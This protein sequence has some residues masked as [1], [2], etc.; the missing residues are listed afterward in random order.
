M[1]VS[2]NH[3]GQNKHSYRKLNHSEVKPRFG[4]NGLALLGLRDIRNA[5][6]RQNN[7]DKAMAVDTETLEHLLETVRRFVEKRLIP[8]ESQVAEDDH[9]PD[10]VIDEMRELGL[11]GLTIPEA[12]GGLGLN[13][14][15][16]C[17]VV[18]ELGLTSPAFR[19]IIGTNNGI[20]SQGLVMD[21]T[22]EQKRHYLPR[23]ATGEIIGSFA[24]TE[25][26][27]GSDSGAVQTKA[28]KQGDDY[29]LSGTKRYI[30]NAGSAQLF[31]VFARTD[32][33]EVG[34]KGVSAF[35]VDANSAG[36]SLSSPY[37]KMGQQGAHV[38]DVMFDECRVPA[39]NI[40]GGVD[41]VH[42]GF[43]TAMK[44]LD[45][46]RIHIS[47]LAVGC[48]KRLIAMSTT[49]AVE[50]K[51][52]GK[53]IAEFQLIQGMLADSQAECYAAECMVLDAAR[54]R[55]NGESVKMIASC[56]K[57]FA[58]EMVGRVADRAVQIHGGA[59]YI[60]EYA[61]SRFYRDV[62]LLRIYEG[63]S[64]IQ[65]TIIARDLIRTFS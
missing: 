57:L 48:A 39:G 18:L 30:T 61:V 34:S 1:V 49:Y 59:G 60:E 13:T 45:R 17:R 8:L 64:Q 28:I 55:D 42:R 44:T 23:L 41:N 24:L 22:E 38:Y 36:I 21:G 50:R 27:A 40:I 33:N 53:P 15:E 56:C 32:Q 35:L 11:F 47:A 43:Q 46:G 29:V 10:D 9:I 3:S 7:G 65:Q 62:R 14:E 2:L 51:Q 20:G 12:Y 58:T 37:K 19:S 5:L 52:F 25:P 31:T 26:D 16:E 54:R 6:Q 4:L 63:T